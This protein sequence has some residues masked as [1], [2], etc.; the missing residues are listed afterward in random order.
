[1]G[2]VARDLVIGQPSANRGRLQRAVGKGRVAAA[3]RRVH[4]IHR[5]GTAAVHDHPR[6]EGFHGAALGIA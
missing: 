2:Q 6:L 3:A 5:T 4:H 1:L